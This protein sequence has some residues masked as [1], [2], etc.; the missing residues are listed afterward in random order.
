MLR[1]AIYLLF[2][3]CWVNCHGQQA[4]TKEALVNDLDEYRDCM[5]VN[6]IDPFEKISKQDFITGIQ[7]IK[8]R[9]PSLNED[10]LL[11]A[12]MQL[13]ARLADEHSILNGFNF[14]VLPFRFYWFKEGWYIIS[15]DNEN[16]AYLNARLLA[17]NNI[18]VNEVIEKIKTILP[19]TSDGYIK[20][21]AP[22]LMVQNR[23]LHGLDIC[24][25][26]KS[27]TLKLLTEKGETIN[28]KFDFTPG[29]AD[30]SNDTRSKSFLRFSKKSHY[31][32]TYVDSAKAMYFNY[33][34]CFPDPVY[35]FAQLVIDFF[36]EAEQKNP[37]KIII[38]LRQND[39]GVRSA[40]KPFIF[41]LYKSKYNK[42]NTIF[43]LTGRKT[44]SA[45]MNNIFDIG[46][47][48]PI[49]TVGEQTGASINHLG[50]PQV[51]TLQNSG[52]QISY[53]TNHI[54]NKPNA[55]G[56]AVP[57]VLITETFGDFMAGKDAA[58]NYVF[59]H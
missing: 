11:V 59:K 48:V 44:F 42:P 7:N 1:A 53:S 13:N 12:V 54:V 37:E 49:T 50:Q 47:V 19:S 2:F 21:S 16:G 17:V 57:D 34:S 3:L 14:A 36:K 25:N 32:F 58:L 31:W 35:P 51:L 26:I 24:D 28:K 43:V 5:V 40:I 4:F 29:A 18:P 9:A 6:D 20:Y 55:T 27:V 38:D 39:G 22:K 33:T 45:G 8:E 41:A 56:P 23:I 15:T 52:L 46:R 30:L 10:E